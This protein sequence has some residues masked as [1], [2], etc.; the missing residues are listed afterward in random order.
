MTVKVYPHQMTGQE[1]IGV[2]YVAG[3]LRRGDKTYKSSGLREDAIC[4]PKTPTRLVPLA[5]LNRAEKI[6]DNPLRVCQYIHSAFCV[7]RET[8]N[9]EDA[10]HVFKDGILEW[11]N[12]ASFSWTDVNQ[13]IVGGNL[14]HPRSKNAQ[15]TKKKGRHVILR[16][17]NFGTDEIETRERIITRI[18]KLGEKMRYSVTDFDKVAL[19]DRRQWEDR[20]LIEY[21][22]CMSRLI[23]LMNDCGTDVK[24]RRLKTLPSRIERLKKPV[25][26]PAY[27]LKID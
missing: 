8:A 14:I 5:V 1:M 22:Q 12:P 26:L 13:V 19:V 7:Y 20:S 24:D 21:D 9:H 2:F 6:L 10:P 27:F 4:S 11:P 23:G 16:E 15:I 17:I 18:D 3:I 25:K